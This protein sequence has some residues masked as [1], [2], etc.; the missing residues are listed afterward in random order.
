MPGRHDTPSTVPAPVWRPLPLVILA[1]AALYAATPMAQALDTWT[2]LACGRHVAAHGVDDA[3]PF[4]FASRPQGGSSW[5]P[6]G[7]INQNW[8]THLLL[9][10][11]VQAFGTGALAVLRVVVYGGVAIGLFA[12]QRLA[13]VRELTAASVVALALL[14][15]RPT[16][17]VRPQ[18]FTNLLVAME[19]VVLAAWTH[20]SSRL[21]WLAVPLFALWSN[22]HGGFVFGF[23]LLL[24]VAAG[25]AVAERVTRRHPAGGP[26]RP[27]RVAL[28]AAA[29]L[30]ACVLASPYRLAN[31]THPLL[32]S[33]SSDAA[34]WRTIEEWRPF[35]EGGLDFHNQ[36]YFVT[37]IAV[38]VVG[39]AAALRLGRVAPGRVAP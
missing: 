38:L 25:R 6:T 19:L 3:D 11:V 39:A 2:A 34:S 24:V 8:L 15:A 35:F 29:A 27:T 28:V 17:E 22:L 7:W 37:W 18:D 16:L 32:V 23:I 9:Y 30:V 10:V 5:H 1:I 31:L 26:V 20:R 12:A 4:A 13:G 14:L 36:W 21:L 33:V